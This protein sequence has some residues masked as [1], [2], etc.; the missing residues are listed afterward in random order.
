MKYFIA[1]FLSLIIWQHSDN[2]IEAHI[3]FIANENHV[4]KDSAL[5]IS[6][7]SVSKVIYQRLTLANPESWIKFNSSEDTVLHM[8]IGIPKITYLEDY[9]PNVEIFENTISDKGLIMSAE[10]KNPPK[11]FH[12][13]FTNTY[14]W[15]LYDQK[16]ALKKNQTYYIS[17]YEIEK[18]TGKL[19][20]GIGYKEQF[21]VSD[22]IT[23]P[24]SINDIQKFHKI[25]NTETE[26]KTQ[27]NKYSHKYIFVSICVL[28]VSVVI[29]I[30]YLRRRLKV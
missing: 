4:N 5:E 20:I 29:L 16:I 17:S 7:I 19:W 11:E 12:E 6:D 18:K 25:S 22:W 13:P 15:I 14:S 2:I 27:S 8:Q 24:A 1:I 9:R 28:F 21:N 23:L 26:T 30:I 10:Y 3:P